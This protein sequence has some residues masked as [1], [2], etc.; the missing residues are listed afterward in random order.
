MAMLQNHGH[1]V[2]HVARGYVDEACDSSARKLSRQ[3]ETLAT[4]VALEVSLAKVSTRLRKEPASTFGK[5]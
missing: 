4:S 5:S 2:G 3:C 1:L